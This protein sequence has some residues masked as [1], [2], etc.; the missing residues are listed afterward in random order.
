[1]KYYARALVL[2]A[3]LL[4][5]GVVGAQERSEEVPFLDGLGDHHREITT[6]SETVQRYFDQGLRLYYAFN[7]AEAVRAFRTAQTLDPTCAMCWWGEAM[8][9]GPNINL[10]MD[11]VSGAAAFEAMQGAV[12]R[13]EYADAREQALIDALATRY[14][15]VPEADRAELD[16]AYADAMEAV[17]QRFPGDSDITTLHAEAVMDLTP[18]DYWI[19]AETPRPAMR[20]ALANLEQV[21]STDPDHPGACHFFIHAVEQFEPGRAVPCAERL[22]ALMPGAGHLVH[23]PG[24]VYIRVGRY[25]DAVEAN[26]HAVHAD[27]TYIR[28]IGPSAGMYTAGYYPHNYDFLAFAAMMIGR[29]DESVSSAL[30]VTATVPPELF[31]TPGMAFLEHWLV[32]PLQMSVRFGQWDEILAAPAPDGALP[33]ATAIWHYA[34]GRA[35]VAKNDVPGARAELTRLSEIVSDP[36]LDGVSMEFNPSRDLLGIARQVLSGWVE[37]EAG[38]AERAVLALEEAVRLEDALVYGEPPEWSVPTRQDLGAVLLLAGRPEDAA[39]VFGED[40][41]HFPDNVWSLH[42]LYEALM[43]QGVMS[44]AEA[45]EAELGRVLEAAEVES[46]SGLAY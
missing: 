21:I 7:H 2:T 38:D 41:E 11:S 27:E 46:L 4:L 26:R 1:M 3:A 31:G 6:A 28:D 34:R 37:L 12:E 13:R 9:F 45:V 25:L 36:R 33:H 5:P 44:D 16:Q 14:V 20:D 43:A 23:M 40:L 32:R 10:P 19:D 39:R 22:A 24:H 17:L 18:W 29:G 15:P 35:F 42:G 30:Q 8:A